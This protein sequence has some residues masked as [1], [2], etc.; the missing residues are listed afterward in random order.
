[1]TSVQGVGQTLG[2]TVQ[3]RLGR[4]VH[5]VRP[6]GAYSSHGREHHECPVPLPA[7]TGSHGQAH[8]H[9][10][11]VV[12]RG[13]VCGQDRVRL[14]CGLVTQDPEGVHDHVEVT[15]QVHRLL[16]Q[17]RVGLGQRGVEL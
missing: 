11:G 3:T 12:D 17:L 1:P 7:K 16:H 10:T 13:V 5:E 14:I 4:A 9:V 6:T 8:R 15:D 2:E